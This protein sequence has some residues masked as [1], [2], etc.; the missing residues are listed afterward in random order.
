MNEDLIPGGKGDNTD[1]RSLDHEQFRKGV[2]VELEH[3]D[4]PNISSEI[5]MD[6]LAEDP[7]Y[8]TKLQAAGLADELDD[9][10]PGIK[11]DSTRLQMGC[12]SIGK[13][14]KLADF[15]KYC[16][17]EVTYE[18][19][20]SNSVLTFDEFF[21]PKETM[22]KQQ[23]VSIIEAA[24]LKFVFEGKPAKVFETHSHARRYFDGHKVDL[25]ILSQ[26]D[27]KSL[28]VIASKLIK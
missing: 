4:D 18:S 12:G 5:A 26:M 1:P 10:D 24:I 17:I 2:K 20:L 22:N 8:Y 13:V 11:K 6:H 16:K 14:K 28:A 15:A 25:S 27:N 21:D 23:L 3:T 19:V 9:E 7:E